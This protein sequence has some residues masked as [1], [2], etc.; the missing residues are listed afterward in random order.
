MGA[1]ALEAIFSIL[2]SLN[3]ADEL[4]P[5]RA[6]QPDA[7]A[8]ARVCWTRRAV[9]SAGVEESLTFFGSMGDALAGELRPASGE[10]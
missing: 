5:R 6:G 9:A 3:T 1:N 10:A 7:V 8:Y 4:L 2:P